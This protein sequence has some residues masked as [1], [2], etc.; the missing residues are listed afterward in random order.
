MALGGVDPDHVPED[1]VPADLHQRL[2]DLGAVLLQPRPAAA[3]EDRDEH[4]RQATRHGSRR[5]RRAGGRL[6]E[7][8]ARDR[9]ARPAERA[10]RA[11]PRLRDRLA[12]RGAEGA[13]RRSRSSGSSASR[14][15]RRGRARAL[16]PRRR[17]PTSRRVAAATSGRFDC[18]VAA[19]VL[20]HL[21]D[22]WS[23]LRRL[24]GAARARLPRGRSRSPTPPTGPPTRRSRA[25]PGR[26]GRRGST[27]P[28]TCAGSRCATRVELLRAAPGCAGRARRAARRGCSGAARG[29][30]RHAGP[31][32]VPA[33]A[34]CHVPARARGAYVRSCA[35]MSAPAR[36][37]QG[38][39][40]PRPLRRARSTATSP[41]RSGAAFARVL[42]D[43]PGKP[44][45]ELRVGLG[46]DMR[47]SAP[48]LAAPLPRRDGR[49]GRARGRRRDGRHRD[50]LLARRLARPRR[51]PDVHR[52]AQPEGLHGREAGRARRGRAVRRR[53]GSARSATLDRGRPRRRARRR[54]L[55]G[56]RHL[57]RLPARP[58]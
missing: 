7:R 36:D 41:R 9:R 17:R 3:A 15:T 31:L 43:L 35:P 55:R 44:A 29:C 48:E 12:G 51:R 24:R 52:L 4:L 39:R 1:R 2:R 30:D 16:R 46:R 45:A 27:T 49:R 54:L 38:L 6:R 50:A 47:L 10:A 14:P 32:R 23:A 20:E 18:L 40:R 37:L 25:G 5:T 58:R 21:V 53:A 57:R 22:P 26:A 8:A 28:R 33:V 42:A 11:R 56:G 19:D 13:R 34:R